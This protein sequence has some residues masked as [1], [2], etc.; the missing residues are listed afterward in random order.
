M[1]N[2]V[3]YNCFGLKYTEKRSNK[4]HSVRRAKSDVSEMIHVLTGIVNMHFILLSSRRRW[5]IEK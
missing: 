2:P 4:C 1:F 3:V 5:A